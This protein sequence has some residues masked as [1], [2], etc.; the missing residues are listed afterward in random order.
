MD[1]FIQTNFKYFTN[2]LQTYESMFG[3]IIQKFTI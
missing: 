3:F 2:L 1:F